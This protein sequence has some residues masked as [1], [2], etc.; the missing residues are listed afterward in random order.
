[1]AYIVLRRWAIRHLIR[2]QRL[3]D[4]EWS[5]EDSHA[6][7]LNIDFWRLASRVA[8]AG[9]IAAVPIAAVFG[10]WYAGLNVLISL[11]GSQARRHS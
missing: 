1:M 5:L 8:L 7:P 2:R 11:I 9:G 6:P 10:D 3:A 4:S